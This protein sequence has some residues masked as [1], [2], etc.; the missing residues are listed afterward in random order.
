MPALE[1]E[2]SP[3]GTLAYSLTGPYRGKE[4]S[5]LAPEDIELETFS[6]RKR[7]QSFPYMVSEGP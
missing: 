2:S 5:N 7:K 1:R 4:R 6:I 3:F